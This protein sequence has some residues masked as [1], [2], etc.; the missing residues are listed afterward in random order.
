MLKHHRTW[1]VAALVGACAVWVAAWVGVGSD[2]ARARAAADA[3]GAYLLRHFHPDA[4]TFDYLYDP[5]QNKV[6]SSY[7][8]L[9][10]AGT[11]YALLTL[12]EATGNVAYRTAAEQALKFLYIQ[13]APC[14]VPHT[15]LRCLYEGGSAKLGGNALAVLALTE[16]VRTTGDTKYLKKAQAYAAW[17]RATETDTGEFTAH[18][19]L[20]DGT[21]TDLVSAYYPGEA[22]FALMR[23]Y[24]LDHDEAWHTAAARAA[25][26][27]IEV[28][29][30]GVA[31]HDLLHD[32]WLLY[33]LN[34][35][36]KVSCEPRYLDHA[37]AIVASIEALQ[38]SGASNPEWD[39][40]FYD[41]PRSTPTATRVEGAAAAH[42]LFV[43]AGD[44]EA[45]AQARRIVERGEAFLLRTQVDAARATQAGL[46]LEGAAGGFTESLDGY[47]IRI[48]YVQHAISALLGYVA[49]EHGTGFPGGSTVR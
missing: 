41:P 3:G 1:V 35:L 36:C 46:S 33:G 45:A 17:I 19:Q 11:T 40:G 10:H 12:Y 32:H 24:A 2:S 14:P 31:P 5:V 43:R 38:H 15:D 39:G 20:K 16:H 21:T 42:E 4:G 25:D 18:E 47:R 7:N 13:E 48:D 6:A 30:R 34:E 26:W 8:L 9:R 27:L 44:R 29:D 23:L 37:R 22:I 28:R 49:V